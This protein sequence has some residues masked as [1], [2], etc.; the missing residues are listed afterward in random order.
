MLFDGKAYVPALRAK[1]GEL[2]GLQALRPDVADKIVPRLIVPPSNERNP[3]QDQLFDGTGFPGIADTISAYW[4]GR[5][6]FLDPSYVL[7]EFGSAEISSWLCSAVKHAKAR[8]VELLPCI[9]FGRLKGETSQS[10]VEA[11]KELGSVFAISV[12]LADVAER[13]DI[14]AFVA[15]LNA[16]GITAEKCV[17]IADF[18]DAD[19][20]DIAL[21]AAIIDDSL[22]DLLAIAP[23]QRCVFQ[24]SNFPTTNPAPKLG[25]DVKV[26]RDEWLVWREVLRI[27]PE[28]RK[29]VVFG[30]YAA[31]SCE[32]SQSKARTGAIPHLRYTSEDFWWVEREKKDSPLRSQIQK[33]A[34]RV[35]EN[36]G[37]FSGSSFSSSDFAIAQMATGE[38][39]SGAAWYWRSLNTG[40][41][42]AFTVSQIG[43]EQGFELIKGDEIALHEQPGLFSDT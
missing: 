12:S 29:R 21:A 35:V 8:G 2:F 39:L 3:D 30:D 36:S 17:V 38:K 28:L 34:K 23:W 6:A 9:E 22:S 10:F 31:D 19:L 25:G 37:C 5:T 24:A 20:A 27:S 33:V 7:D 43:R 41:H 11:I 16:E 14:V 15:T 1:K 32:I 26:S 42:I 13:E 40:R 18:K 4:F